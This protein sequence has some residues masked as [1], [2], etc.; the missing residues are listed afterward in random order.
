MT[1]EVGLARASKK[2]D[3]DAAEVAWRKA[4]D[5]DDEDEVEV[6]SSSYPGDHGGKV[7]G[8]AVAEE[9]SNSGGGER[10]M[11][12]GASLPWTKSM[13][14]RSSR[15]KRGAMMMKIFQSAKIMRVC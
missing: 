13:P 12:L 15:S 14:A 6:P 3:G 1:N 8:A 4:P 5:D 10:P 9:A 7:S 11:P 2:D